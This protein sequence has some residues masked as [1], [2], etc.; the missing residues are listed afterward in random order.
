MRWAQACSDSGV[1]GASWDF[2]ALS[3]LITASRPD[4]SCLR[5]AA[6]SATQ[7]FALRQP[8]FGSRCNVGN[9]PTLCSWFPELDTLGGSE[10]G[11]VM[12]QD[13]RHF[14]SLVRFPSKT[15]HRVLGAPQRC[16]QIPSRF[17]HVQSL[18]NPSPSVPTRRPPRRTEK[19][20][21]GWASR[22]ADFLHEREAAWTTETPLPSVPGKMKS[23]TGSRR[24]KG[25][26]VRI[27]SL[28]RIMQCLVPCA[29]GRETH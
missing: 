26:P 28:A 25:G 19:Q 18:V 4:R 8:G 22:I 15:W 27:I 2:L 24:K 13:T 3:I 29:Y 11:T 10:P 9:Y 17:R 20:R 23:G 5:T 12:A 14:N 21:T 7:A 16:S 6:I 1:R